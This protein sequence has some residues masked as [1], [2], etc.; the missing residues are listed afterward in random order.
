MSPCANA[1]PVGCNDRVAFFQFQQSQ[2]YGRI[3]GRQQ[4]I[5]FE[6]QFIGK[7]VKIRAAALIDQNFKQTRP[8]PPGRVCGSIRMRPPFRTARLSLEVRTRWQFRMILARQRP[9][10]QIDQLDEPRIL[11]VAVVGEYQR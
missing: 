3:D 7:R 6:A 2:Q 5:H 10:D 9:V 11:A 8:C 4:R 1:W